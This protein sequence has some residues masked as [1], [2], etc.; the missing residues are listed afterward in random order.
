MPVRV[1]EKERLDAAMG[2]LAT[3]WYV[4]LLDAGMARC[5]KIG[6]PLTDLQ[7]FTLLTAAQLALGDWSAGPPGT[8]ADRE[9]G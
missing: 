4:Q 8:D 6:A 7:R 3:R 2:E 9:T 5:E 1:N